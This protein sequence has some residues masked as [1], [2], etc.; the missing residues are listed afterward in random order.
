M[1]PAKKKKIYDDDAPTVVEIQRPT[2]R[3]SSDNLVKEFVN[4]CK[5]PSRAKFGLP[6]KGKGVT[7]K[8]DA[9]KPILTL[10]KART[11]SEIQISNTSD[12]DLPELDLPDLNSPILSVN[13]S[14]KSSASKVKAKTKNTNA[15]VA[16]NLKKPSTSESRSAKRLSAVDE[17]LNL[18]KQAAKAMEE[19]NKGAKTNRRSAHDSSNKALPSEGKGK[20]KTPK[21]SALNDSDD[22]LEV[23]LA[24]IE[25]AIMDEKEMSKKKKVQD[26]ISSSS[27][28]QTKGKGKANSAASPN[29]PR[30]T[31]P[32]KKA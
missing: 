19:E 21:K 12:D 9:N 16:S 26:K 11:I 7:K 20:I 25:Q 18:I 8:K 1:S 32:R 3:S 10:K 14:S 27:S 28:N 24:K 23:S 4:G 15:S 6:P 29:V 2:S 30:R 5:K 13:E 17:D 22:K 31:S